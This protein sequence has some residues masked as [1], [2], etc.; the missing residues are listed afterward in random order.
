MKKKLRFGLAEGA[1][2]GLPVGRHVNVK[3]RINDKL[4][5]RSYTP[6]STG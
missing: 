1:T 3:A 4:V 6:I 2:F 5:M